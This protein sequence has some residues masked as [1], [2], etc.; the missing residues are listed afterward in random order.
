MTRVYAVF[1]F[2]SCSRCA[3]LATVLLAVPGR[4][5]WRI[6]LGAQRAWL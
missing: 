2:V 3:L 4:N 6:Y 5:Q 1:T